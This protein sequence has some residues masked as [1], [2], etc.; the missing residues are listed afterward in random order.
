MK[1]DIRVVAVGVLLVISPLL[2]R[3]GVVPV[4]LVLF[5]ATALYMTVQERAVTGVFIALLG[6][7]PFAAGPQGGQTACRIH[8]RRLHKKIGLAI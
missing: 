3:A 5:G 1:L 6:V 7:V 8:I 2:L 4:L